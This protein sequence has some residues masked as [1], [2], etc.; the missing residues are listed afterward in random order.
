MSC[1]T[2]KGGA[3][4]VKR[5]QI[6]S[7][8]ASASYALNVRLADDRWAAQAW[9][10]AWHRTGTHEQRIAVDFICRNNNIN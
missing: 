8:K 9:R 2:A 6:K 5:Q 10:Q 7:D 4:A 3:D 1:I